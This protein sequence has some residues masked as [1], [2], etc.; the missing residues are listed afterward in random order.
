MR[1]LLRRCQR[2]AAADIA[3]CSGRYG[4]FI[5]PHEDAGLVV[6]APNLHTS[7]HLQRSGEG[8]DGDLRCLESAMP[9]A[10]D[11]FALIFLTCA[12]ETARD[13]VGLAAECARLLEPEG[14][15]LVLGLN[16]LSPAHL[17]WMFSGIKAWSPEATATLLTGLGLEVVGSRYLGA[18]WS[19]RTT[20]A[21]DIAGARARGSPLRSGFLLEARRRDPGL[22]P[23]RVQSS[24]VRIGS[25]ARAGSVR[26]RIDP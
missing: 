25:G 12:F 19:A 5:E 2:D 18:R 9:L 23:L 8:F 26:M 4:L 16:P 22:T 15:L 6:A 21:I 10:D 7:V 20:A 24:R 14:T 1:G 17:R 13:A 11:S 3:R